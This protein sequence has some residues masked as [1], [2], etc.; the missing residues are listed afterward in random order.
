MNTR[1]YQKLLFIMILILSLA[2]GACTRSASTP[3]PGE[4]TGD[5]PAAV[6]GQQATMEAVR[7]A[8][9][10]QTAQAGAPEEEPTVTMEPTD[11]PATETP[12]PSDTPETDETADS[13]GTEETTDPISTS[14]PGGT[15]EYTVLQGE[16]VYSIASKF[17]IDGQAIIDLN[18]LEAPYSLTVGQ[19][20]LIPSSNTTVPTA[21]SPTQSATTSAG[22]TQY[23][24][25]EGEWVYS[26]ARKFGVDPQA[27]IDANNLPAPYTLHPGDV[28][29]IP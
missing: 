11:I 18:N 13:T 5:V 16:W 21:A 3:P 23:T 27:I 24:V 20:L 26:I 22:G 15:T 10:T 1:Q 6:S 29:T 12:E 17:N 8:L 14:S 2:V 9:L 19:V 4:E 7:A 28:L 25:L